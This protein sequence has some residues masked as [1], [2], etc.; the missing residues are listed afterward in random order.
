[1][2]KTTENKNFYSLNP[3]FEDFPFFSVF[4]KAKTHA[5]MKADIEENDSHYLLS[6]DVPGFKKE[7]IEISLDDGYL[8]V[9]AEIKKA[10]HESQNTYLR[11]E[12]FFGTYTRSFY[13][14]DFDINCIEAG[15]HEGVLYIS[16]PKECCKKENKKFVQIK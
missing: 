16:I 9:K 10:P 6:M 12:R 2:D 1:M 7:N 8:V 3:F 15:L 14:G 13:V 11:K 5:V 4:D